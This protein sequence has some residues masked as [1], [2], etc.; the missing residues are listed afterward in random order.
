M[1]TTAAKPIQPQPFVHN[2]NIARRAGSYGK[3]S[4]APQS[5]AKTQ[6]CPYHQVIAKYKISVPLLGSGLDEVKQVTSV[7][8]RAITAA[9][10]ISVTNDS[11]KANAARYPVDHR[12]AF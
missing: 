3:S 1:L 8:K 5:G 9:A 10:G 2:L 4:K 12:P 11:G 6:G 7:C